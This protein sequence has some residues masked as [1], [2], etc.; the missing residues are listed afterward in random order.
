[1]EMA[2]KMEGQIVYEKAIC[3]LD[4]LL[5]EIDRRAGEDDTFDVLE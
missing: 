5:S 1:M 2:K 4:N 3:G